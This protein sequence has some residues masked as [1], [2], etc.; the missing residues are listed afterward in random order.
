MRTLYYASL[1][2]LL[3]SVYIVNAFAQTTLPSQISTGLK[4]WS[5]ENPQEKIYLQTDR[6]AYIASEKIWFKIWAFLDQQPAFLSKIVYTDLIN[7]SGRVVLKQM[8]EL[9]SLGTASGYLEI[10]A[11]LSSGNYLIRSY[12]LWMLNYPSFVTSESIYIYNSDYKTKFNTTR[13]ALYMQFFPEGGHLV[14]GLLSRVAFKAVNEKGLPINVVGRLVNDKGETITTLR[15]EHDGMGLFDFT[16]IANNHYKVLIDG[17]A[18]PF[19]LP[20]IE[21]EGITVR[22]DNSKPNRI[23]V[24]LERNETNKDVY[25]RLYISASINGKPVFLN[26]FNFDEGL[27]AAAISKKDL[28]PGI[29]HITIFHPNGNIVAERLTFIDNYPLQQPS[30]QQTNAREQNGVVYLTFRIDSLTTTS[31]SLLC[32]DASLVSPIYTKNNLISALFLTSDLTGWINNPGYYVKDKLPERAKHLD[33]LLMTHGWKRYN[34]KDVISSA[35]IPLQFPVETGISLKGKVTKIGSKEIIK[36]GKVSFVIKAEDSTTMLSDAILTDKGEFI[37]NGIRFFKNA[38]VYYQGTN[39]KKEKYLVD[40]SFYPSYIDTLAKITAS[41]PVSLDTVSAG[42]ETPASVY[43][44]SKLLHVDSTMSNYKSLKEII[45]Q[46]KRKLPRKDSLNM[47]YASPGIFQSGLSL[48]PS[49][50]Q[51]NQNIWYYLQ[52][53]VPGLRVEGTF[54]PNVYFTRYSDLQI[55]GSEEPL[56]DAF[57]N[58]EVNGVLLNRGGIAFYLNEV[59]VPQEVV[60]TLVL[61]D[62]ALVKVLRTEAAALGIPSGAI[63]IYTKKGVNAMKRVY[64]KEFSNRKLTGY[65]VNNSFYALPVNTSINSTPQPTLLWN[66]GISPKDKSIVIPVDGRIK[67]K[68]IR[69]ILQG[70]DG[71]GRIN[72]TEQVLEINYKN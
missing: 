67:P 4:K 7:D 59:N 24:S 18:E 47:T 55:P 51:S 20:V 63:A 53:Q 52:S 43:L 2:L 23:F 5:E 17:I 32:S 54:N 42:G 16:P 27:S 36:D 26:E 38:D 1:L 72:L 37:V 46:G 41:N 66:A 19:A 10:P 57:G 48:D 39:S 44:K 35:S 11:E 30:I 13:P 70:I 49:E 3:F 65:T 6:N 29:L 62:V 64:D 50:K 21:K 28:P 68:A 40:V 9:D 58:R 8:Y 61:S 69:F 15:S 45:I 25:N 33:L 60:E 22:V 31:N 34:W 56:A 71:E 14:Q 12:T